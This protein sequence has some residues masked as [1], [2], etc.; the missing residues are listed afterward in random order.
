MNRNELED[1]NNTKLKGLLPKEFQIKIAGNPF[2]PKDWKPPDKDFGKNCGVDLTTYFAWLLL[3][4]ET[5]FVYRD[6]MRTL[7]E[8]NPLI[9]QEQLNREIEEFKQRTPIFKDFEKL[10]ARMEEDDNRLRK[11]ECYFYPNGGSV[12]M[13]Y[14]FMRQRACLKMGGY[15]NPDLSAEDYA[16]IWNE[17]S[18]IHEAW[19]RGSQMIENS[20]NEDMTTEEAFKVAR[21]LVENLWW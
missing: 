3:K 9:T 11:G 14:K 20:F 2:H 7:C 6:K 18:A 19:A 8:E 5:T 16:K 12:F 4:E 13:D 17:D 15:S 1:K 10:R 21:K